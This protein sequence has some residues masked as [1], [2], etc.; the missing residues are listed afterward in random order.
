MITTQFTDDNN[1]GRQKTHVFIPI[2]FIKRRKRSKRPNRLQSQKYCITFR[3]KKL[4]KARLQFERN[5]LRKKKKKHYVTS[6]IQNTLHAF[7][8]RFLNPPNDPE[9][10]IHWKPG[11]DVWKFSL[12]INPAPTLSLSSGSHITLRPLV[13]INIPIVTRALMHWCSHFSST[14]QVIDR[15]WPSVSALVPISCISDTDMD[16]RGPYLW[17]PDRQVNN[18]A[19]LFSSLST[20]KYCAEVMCLDPSRL[21]DELLMFCHLSSALAAKPCVWLQNRRSSTVV[22]NHHRRRWTRLH[23]LRQNASLGG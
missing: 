2:L 5:V 13:K 19:Q 9:S 10:G 15:K 3:L 22:T 17:Y 1:G 6:S 14:D 20:S 23:L 11:M 16:S 4:W 18:D 12:S 8:S 21:A 7:P